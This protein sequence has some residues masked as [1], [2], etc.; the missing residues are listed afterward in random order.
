L[1]EFFVFIFSAFF[2]SSAIFIVN[3]K[4][5]SSSLISMMLRSSSGAKYAAVG[6]FASALLFLGLALVYWLAYQLAP[7][8]LSVVLIL[9]TS[10]FCLR[11]IL[12]AAKAAY[13]K[14]MRL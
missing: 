6:H 5:A 3:V 7:A 11:S 4:T 14:G 9:P 8:S 13:S 1:G 2:I 12:A 10:A